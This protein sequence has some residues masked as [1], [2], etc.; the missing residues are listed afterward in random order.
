MS[1]PDVPIRIC[2]CIGYPDGPELR[3]IQ[4]VLTDL[5]AMM[6]LDPVA[7]V[8]SPVRYQAL[9]D[10]VLGDTDNV[11]L[12]SLYNPVTGTSV[13]LLRVPF[14]ISDDAVIPISFMPY[15]G[16]G[17]LD[18]WLDFTLSRHDTLL[19]TPDYIGEDSPE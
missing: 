16:K 7:L 13:R 2:G 3:A 5:W 10:E 17:T 18:D 14:V 6:M 1:A 19:G 12:S 9:Y 11:G 8:L 15:L 4:Q